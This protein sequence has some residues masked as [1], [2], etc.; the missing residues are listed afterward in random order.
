MYIFFPF[1]SFVLLL[2]WLYG[3][4]FN[5]ISI[6]CNQIGILYELRLWDIKLYLVLLMADQR[7]S[8]IHL[9]HK[10]FWHTQ[11]LR[12]S[13]FFVSLE[14]RLVV[15]VHCQYYNKNSTISCPYFDFQMN[16]PF[17]LDIF[18]D[19]LVI[20]HTGYFL[21]LKLWFYMQRLC[22]LPKRV[23]WLIW[24]PFGL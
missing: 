8:T 14:I 16:Y 3:A 4:V 15:T 17:T 10:I 19:R 12:M 22:K 23:I 5:V 2:L 11:E 21:P 9:Y 6:L 18:A 24:I 13:F 20:W 7:N 1:W